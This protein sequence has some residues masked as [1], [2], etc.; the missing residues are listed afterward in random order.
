MVLVEIVEFIIDVDRSSHRCR[1]IYVHCAC[2]L[3]ATRIIVSDYELCDP[4][5]I[6]LEHDADWNEYGWQDE[7]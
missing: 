6:D 1:D 2:R 7:K 4:V 5:A 3:A